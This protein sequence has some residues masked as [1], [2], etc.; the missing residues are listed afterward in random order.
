MLSDGHLNRRSDTANA[1]F[2]FAQSGKHEK[3]GYFQLVFDLFASCMTSATLA[4]G[5][6][7][8]PLHKGSA[9]IRI[10]FSTIALPCFNEYYSLFYSGGIKIVPSNIGEL[11]TV[12]PTG[13]K[14]WSCSLNNG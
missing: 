3:H 12:P 13:G 14:M 2:M 9:Y 5:L 7:I 1:R 8:K 10:S 6:V 11:L 4:A